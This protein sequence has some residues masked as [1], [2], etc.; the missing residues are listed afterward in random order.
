M[1]VSTNILQFGAVVF[2]ST[3]STVAVAQHLFSCEEA[4]PREVAMHAGNEFRELPVIFPQGKLYCSNGSLAYQKLYPHGLQKLSD[5]DAVAVALHSVEEACAGHSRELC[6]K[7]QARL[8]KLRAAI[9]TC[10]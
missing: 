10:V 5:E 1:K 2:L 4:K 8:S 9:R 6:K 3:F 7:Y